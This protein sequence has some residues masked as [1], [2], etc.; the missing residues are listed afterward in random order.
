MYDDNLIGLKGLYF[1]MDNVVTRSTNW[2][3][4]QEV[5]I[6]SAVHDYM[7]LTSTGHKDFCLIL[8]QIRIYVC[9]QWHQILK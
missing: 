7:Y 3:M 4:P 5:G 6:V 2:T 1:R 8:G 9:F